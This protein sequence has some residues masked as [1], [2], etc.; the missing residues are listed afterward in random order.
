MGMDELFQNDQDADGFTKRG[1]QGA[2]ASKKNSSPHLAPL[3]DR[4][5]PQLFSDL[6]GQEKIWAKGTPLWTLASDDRFNSLIFWGPPGTGKTSLAHV[7]GRGTSAKVRRPVVVMSAVQHGVKDIRTQ[8]SLSEDRLARGEASLLIFMDEI[9]RLSKSQQDVLLPALESGICRFIGA[10]TENPSFEVNAAILSRSL[11]FKFERHSVDSLCRLIT[12]ALIPE[13]AAHYQIERT[14]MTAEVIA[15]IA[16]AADGDARRAINLLDAVLASAPAEKSPIDVAALSEIGVSL[17]L[18]YDRAG[19]QHYDTISA[20]IKSIRASH[21]DAAVY[22][23][24]RMLAAGE[25]PVFIARRIVIAASEDIGNANPTALLVAMN[26]MQAVQLL[27]M[28]EARIILSQA[29][30]YLAASPKSNRAYLAINKALEDVETYGGLEIPMHLRNAPT[31][32]MKEIGYGK[33]YAYAHDDL[34]GAQALA[35]LPK[36]LQGKRYYEPSDHGVE[37]QLKKN[38]AALRPKAD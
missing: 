6:V 13:N 19:D 18:N 33:G 21:P 14:D 25:D 16:R 38:L 26:A 36:R 28:P 10:T 4:M 1:V 11:V 15:A 24:A 2:G 31:K 8:L 5:R 9:H 32:F 27:G 35:Y 23:L 20:F 29:V 3:A 37:A 7:I 22:Y 30:T 12:R 17:N 34:K